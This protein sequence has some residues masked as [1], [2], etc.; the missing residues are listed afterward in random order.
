MTQ[1]VNENENDLPGKVV[2][3]FRS[4]VLFWKPL[5]NLNFF[6]YIYFL[7]LGDWRWRHIVFS[8]SGTIPWKMKIFIAGIF[9]M[10]FIIFSSSIKT[11]SRFPISQISVLGA[12]I[13]SISHT[14]RN[15]WLVAL[16][17]LHRRLFIKKRNLQCFLKAIKTAIFKFCN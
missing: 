14:W 5:L 11:K 9:Y 3:C 7:N 2:H 12:I 16:P 10:L 6:E 15:V 1:I 8:F 4:E 13:L 17:Y